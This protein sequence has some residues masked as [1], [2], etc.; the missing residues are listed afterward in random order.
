M[1]LFLEDEM[2]MNTN[3]DQ[4]L[5]IFHASACT[6]YN[7]EFVLQNQFDNLEFMT[8]LDLLRDDVIAA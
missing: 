1:D 3:K 6:P 5:L 7:S 4:H 8:E 2:L